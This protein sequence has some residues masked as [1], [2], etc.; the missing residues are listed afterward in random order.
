M[1]SGLGV[2]G[3]GCRHQRRDFTAEHAEAAE[4]RGKVEK[5]AILC[6]S[7]SLCD[8]GVLGGESLAFLGATTRP[9]WLDS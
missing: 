8:H 4:K 9:T 7:L 6:F 2:S 3:W 1:V 5:I